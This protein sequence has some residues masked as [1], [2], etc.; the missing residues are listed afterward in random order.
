MAQGRAY[1]RVLVGHHGSSDGP[2]ADQHTAF[3]AA[4]VDGRRKLIRYALVVVSAG[5]PRA[6]IFGRV[7]L[8]GKPGFETFLTFESDLVRTKPYSHDYSSRQ[9]HQPLVQR[10]CQLS[11]RP[12]HGKSLKVK[13]HEEDVTGTPFPHTFLRDGLDVSVKPPP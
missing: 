1:P 5:M 12:G 7:S 13:E 3:D 8:S 9:I 10:V 2:A 11:E 6:N 4:R